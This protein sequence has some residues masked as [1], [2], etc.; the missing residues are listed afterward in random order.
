MNVKVSLRATEKNGNPTTGIAKLYVANRWQ[1]ASSAQ[2]KRLQFVSHVS[3]NLLEAKN[4]LAE[5]I[6]GDADGEVLGRGYVFLFYNIW[7]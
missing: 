4:T 3:L 2:L 1:S 7:L 6:Y 5:T